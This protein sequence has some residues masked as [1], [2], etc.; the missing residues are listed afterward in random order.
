MT[1]RTDY[2]K[3]EA[4]ESQF[5]D[6]AFSE[7]GEVDGKD[8]VGVL[9]PTPASSYGYQ[10]GDTM[11]DYDDDDRDERAAAAKRSQMTKHQNI[12]EIIANLG[13][14]DEMDDLHPA[15]KHRLRDFRFAQQ[16][17]REKYGD[18]RPWGILGLYDHLAGIR[19]D[20]EWAEDAAW[21]RQHS[22]PY[23]SWTDFEQ[24][25]AKGYNRPFFTFFVLILCTIM[26]VV[27][28]AVNGWKLEPL[29]VNPMVGPSAETLL[30]LGAK[31]SSLIVNEGEWWRLFTPMVLHA[32]IIHYAL[33]MLALYFVGSA[34]EQSHGFVNAAVGFVIAGVGGTILSAI[35][36]P[37]YISVG[38]SG[39]IFG[40]IGMC[41]SDIIVNWSLLFIDTGS[42]NDNGVKNV[43]VLFWLVV[44]I[45][46]NCLIGMT[47]FVD[48]FTHLGG[49]VYG[50]L[51][52]LSTIERLEAGFFGLRSGTWNKIQHGCVRFGGL[53]LSVICIMVT[54]VVL[55]ESEGGRTTPCSGCRYV[56]CVP[57]PP[58]SQDKWW[59]CDDCN[60]VTADALRSDNSEVYEFLDLTCPNGVIERI[61]ITDDE[62]S[63]RNVVRQHLPAY[64]RSTCESV[65]NTD[66]L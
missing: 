51:C 52:G 33:N 7:E 39:G 3:D 17:R 61:N 50:F 57:F 37:Q 9:H 38:A 66:R 26:L 53:V 42:N 2:W 19:I 1:S 58:W 35:F 45:V 49:M 14:M 48:N 41:I 64:C 5:S 16:K 32:G 56:S 22:E 27:S 4:R 11:E 23:L 21:R 55:V 20:L 62:L 30:K 12:S 54:V 24:E 43:M 28:I 18:D 8:Q 59:Y 13:R 6:K 40:F 36:L 63:D 34:I 65:Y 15:L 47:P 60:I 10:S 29:S 25:R 31:Q 44:D 46:L